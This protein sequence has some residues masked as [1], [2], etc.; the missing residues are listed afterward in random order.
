MIARK[1]HLNRSFAVAAL[2]AAIVAFGAITPTQ[3]AGGPRA[4][5]ATWA[6][7]HQVDPGPESRPSGADPTG[8]HNQQEFRRQT[9]RY[10]M[11]ATIDGSA[12][13]LRLSNQYGS[14]PVTIGKASVAIRT[15]GKA[16]DPATIRFLS[17][18]G[19]RQITIQPGD[20]AWSDPV[21]LHVSKFSDIAVSLY[22]V[23]AKGTYSGH[24]AA[25]NT[26]WFSARDTGDLT[27]DFTGAGLGWPA[28]TWLWAQELDVMSEARPVVVAIGDSITDGHLIAPESNAEWPSLLAQRLGGDV[29]VINA[30]INGNVLLSPGSGEYGRAVVDRFDHDALD[31]SGVTHVVLLAGTNDIRRGS[32]AA[33]LADGYRQLVARAHARGVRVIAGTITPRDDQPWGWVPAKHNPI[34]RQINHWI[35][36]AGIFDGIVDFDAATRDSSNPDF[37]R[38]DYDSGDRLHPNAA[39]H[40]GLADAVNLG[41]FR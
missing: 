24:R 20:E 18:A 17:F 6:T 29:S 38:L 15:V 36:T 4:L 9:V 13:R 39:G 40:R 32:T 33:Q 26:A 5:R 22:V 1:Q 16:V 10:V 3:A 34:R 8:G 19:S 27:A 35:R 37:L 2:L 25:K 23:S 30:G 7:S 14:G 21:P 11:R 28:L 12:L 31:V 41:F